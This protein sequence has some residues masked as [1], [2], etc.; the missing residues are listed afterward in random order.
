[1]LNLSMAPELNYDQLIFKIEILKD[2][3]ITL[4]RK[5][6][7][8]FEF[9]SNLLLGR[10]P[11]RHWCTIRIRPT[12]EKFMKQ[13]I[14][15]FLIRHLAAMTC[16]V[17]TILILKPFEPYL[18]I[19][20]I[21]L[22]FLLPVLV[23]TVYWGLTAGV[24]ASIF[25]FLGFNFYFIQP[26]NTLAVHQTQD[27]ITLIIFLLVSVV[28]SQFIGRS[29]EGAALAQSRE[30]EAT[31]LYELI[32]ALS[33]LRDPQ[34]IAD[35][36]ANQTMRAFTVDQ[37][38]IKIND[39]QG[40][41]QSMI[42]SSKKMSQPEGRLY[43]IPMKTAR[44]DE[45]E[46]HLWHKNPLSSQEE[47]LLEA[48][49]N[50]GALT[51]E[52]VN[53]I[54]SENK[55]RV[56]EESDRLKSSLLNSVSHE[57]R[58]PLAAIKTS[59]SFL[60]SGS[61]DLNNAAGQELLATI[62]EET[63][64]LNL[65]VGNLLDMSRIESGALYPQKRWNSISEIAMGVVN[66]MRKQLQDHHLEIDF[67]QDLPLVDYVMIS[68]VFTNLISNSVKYAPPQTSI[69][70]NAFEEQDSLHVQVSNQGPPVPPEHLKQIFDKFHRITEADRVT[71]TGLGLSI[72][73]GIIE[74]H[75]GKIWAENLAKSF[76]FHFTLPLRL[77]GILPQYPK[78]PND[79]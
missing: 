58:S 68:Q 34:K 39:D 75:G 33:S 46:I 21:A 55:A 44:T 16:I 65:L 12:M 1:M 6:K 57:L 74:A 43:T 8:R 41:P 78:D 7:T 73:K 53:L 36:L 15:L 56:L 3:N 17:A 60:R 64:Q 25:A 24:L 48:F 72:C 45:G 2:I 77:D 71:G 69:I 79:E 22:I 66:K 42:K 52:R 19:Q 28:M 50:Q 54:K 61:E 47:R 38:E 35:V 23:S 29:R 5:A 20:V 30:R 32:S 14:I 9:F 76:V 62:E 70:L 13:N 26:Y 63:D 49:A 59:V 51:L 4:E 27:L 10:S 11:N 40:K 67:P 18:A 31:L 37:V